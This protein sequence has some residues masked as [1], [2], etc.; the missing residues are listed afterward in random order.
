MR[1]AAILAVL[2]TL[3]LGLPGTAQEQMTKFFQPNSPTPDAFFGDAVSASAARAVIGAPRDAGAGGNVGAAY[4]MQLTPAGWAFATEL[5]PNE[6]QLISFYGTSV[7]L[8]GER[9]L[10]GANFAPGAIQS[11]GAAY[12]FERTGSVTW[13]NTAKLFE[14]GGDGADRFGEAVDLDGDRALVSAFSDD[15]VFPDAGSAFIF[16]LVG[17]SWVQSAKLTASDAASKQFL[18]DAVAL[19]GDTALVGALRADL[20]T[21]AVYVFELAAG[22][23]SQSA[24]LTPSDPLSEHF[25][26]AVALD[27]DRALVGAPW[28]DAL[29]NTSGAVYA[30]ERTPGG[31]VEVQKINASDAASSDLFGTSIALEGNLALVGSPGDDDA[32]FGST[33]CSSGSVYVYELQNGVWI[34]TGKF[35]GD[36]TQ[37]GDEFGRAVSLA[38]DFGDIAVVGAPEDDFPTDDNGSAYAFLLPTL[39]GTPAALSAST[40]GAQ[41]LALDARLEHAGRPYLLLGSL[42][43]TLPGVPLKGQVLPLVPDDYTVTSLLAP[44]VPPLAASFGL[45]DAQGRATAGFTLFSGLSPAVVGL[46][47]HHAYVVLDPVTAEVRLASNAAPLAID[48]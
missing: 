38:R 36:D 39:T 21:G 9:A 33:S 22:S 2:A 1:R 3:K 32:C 40:G 4:L 16:D 46:E 15:H 30:F 26:E 23:W 24:R 44:N 31:W 13:V 17:G 20:F 48:P 41:L 43:G 10:V 6:P 11:T 47:V 42:S 5:V 37:K 35:A 28:D 29:G 12:V 14:V 19:D 45:L 25:G 7:A 8:S 18:G 27:G 34:E